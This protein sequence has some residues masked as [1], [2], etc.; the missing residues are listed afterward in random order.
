MDKRSCKRCGES[1][2]PRKEITISCPRCRSRKWEELE[3]KRKTRVDHVVA[4]IYK[5]DHRQRLELLR[6][7]GDHIERI[8]GIPT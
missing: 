3:I 7:L 1:W 8:Q 4:L 6:W 5:L 2:V